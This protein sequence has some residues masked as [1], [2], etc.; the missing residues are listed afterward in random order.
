MEPEEDSSAEELQ[1]KESKEVVPLNT[2]VL[3]SNLKLAYNLTRNSDGS[4]NR[5]LDEFLDRKVPV[6]S[7]EREDDPVTFMDVTIDRTSGIWSRIFIP[8][9]S[10]NNNASSTTHGT[11]IFFYFHGGSFVHMSAN[12][13]V[14]HT[15]C[16]QLARLC[17][18][19][20]ISVNYRRAPEHKYPAAYN[21]CYAALT[22]LKVQV[23]RGVAHAW[24]PR[25]AD[26]GRCFLVGDSNGG[27]IVH[28]VGVRAAESGA[29]L[30]PLRVAGHILI[31]PMF[32]GNRRTQSELRFDGQYFVTIK[33][34]DFYWQS[35][36][37]AGADR[38]HP[39]CNIFGPSSRSLEGVVLPPSL[40]AVAGLDMIKDWQLQ[41]VEGMRNAGKDV[42]LLFLE[43][44]TVGFFIFPNTGHFH[45]LMDKITAFIDRDGDQHLTRRTGITRRTTT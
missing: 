45:R 28:H 24:L 34:R 21:D 12:S 40:V 10:H 31:I 32:G 43:E 26:L 16:Q 38:D 13:A 14:Y 30:G 2:W 27:N 17:Q 18:A 5:N 25:T 29:E 15:V 9:A 37:P 23:L 20:V 35:F 6:S 42:E 41:Y 1:L 39:A 4:F 36:L 8:R 7:V 11:P 44:A 33:D 22:W 3:I 19:V